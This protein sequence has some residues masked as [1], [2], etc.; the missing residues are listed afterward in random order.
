MSDTDVAVVSG[1]LL[2]KLGS[3]INYNQPNEKA[4]DGERVVVSVC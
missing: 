3:L 4:V 1:W 2:T